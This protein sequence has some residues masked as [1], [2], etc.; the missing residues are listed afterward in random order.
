MD[1]QCQRFTP[2]YM[3]SLSMKNFDSSVVFAMQTFQK[4]NFSDMM[5][6]GKNFKSACTSGG[7]I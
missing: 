5:F 6:W 2:V 1:K 7:E 3:H 4:L